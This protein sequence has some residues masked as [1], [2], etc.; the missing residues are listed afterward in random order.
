M[1]CLP[2]RVSF[3]SLISYYILSHKPSHTHT[4]HPL[5]HSFLSLS[6]GKGGEENSSAHDTISTQQRNNSLRPPKATPFHPDAWFKQ[7]L[8]WC[9]QTGKTFS[10]EL[11]YRANSAILPGTVRLTFYQ[12][13]YWRK[14][15]GGDPS[16]CFTFVVLLLSPLPVCSLFLCACV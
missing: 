4:P 8:L 13:N 10:V 5:G 9:N 7:N 6:Y 16:L 12:K 11:E 2:P 14:I 1:T 3:S 15:Q